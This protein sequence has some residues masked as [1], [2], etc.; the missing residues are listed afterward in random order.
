MKKSQTFNECCFYLRMKSTKK[1]GITLF[2]LIFAFL[3]TMA[4][5]TYAQKTVS[6]KVSD[7]AGEPI[8][9]VTVI[10]KGTTNGSV[11]DMDGIYT[12]GNI[13]EDGI[14]QFSFVGM[15]TQEI[16]VGTQTTIN[17]TLVAD[18]LGL[19]EVVIVGYGTQKKGNLTGSVATIKSEDLVRAP[20]ASTSNAITGRMPGVITKQGSGSPG[21][22]GARISIRGFGEPLVIVDGVVGNFNIIDANEIESISVLKDASAAIYGARAG[23]GVIL[24]TTKRGTS[25]KPKITLNSSYTSQ[26]NTQFLEP[27]S[28]GQ[29]AE[30]QR[31]EWHEKG[32]IGAAPFSEED[33]AKYYAG[34]D[35][36]YPNTNWFDEIMRSS[37]PMLQ[38]NLSLSGGTEDI[39][40]F[41]FLGYLNQQSFLK[42]NDGKYNRYNVRANLDTKITNDLSVQFDVSTIIG[43]RKY[44]WRGANEGGA[45]FQDLWDQQPTYQAFT[46]SEK[47]YPYTGSITS[48]V[49][50]SIREGH[51]Y[52]DDNK[53]NVKGRLGFLY[54][55]PFVKG[56]SAKAFANYSKDYNRQK[57]YER[58]Y[59]TYTYENETDEYIYVSTLNNSRLTHRD[60]EYQEITGQFSLN[61]ERTFNDHTVSALALYEFIDIKSSL[62]TATRGQFLVPDIDYLFGG[63]E[64]GMS[65]NGSAAETGRVSFIGRLNYSYKGKYLFESTI[66]RD[67]SAKF[68]SDSRWGTF[69]SVSLGWR[70]S[71]ESFIADNLPALNNLKLR[72]GAS[73]TGVDDVGN[74]QYLAGYNFRES[75]TFGTSLQKTLWSKGVANPNLS[76]EEITIYNLGL[77]YGLWNNKLYGEIDVFSRDRE[78]IAG[79]PSTSL[80][81]TIGIEPP[82]LNLNSQNTKGFE[83]VIG[84]ANTWNGLKYDISANVSYAR[85]KWIYFDEPE[86][87]DE[88]DIRLNQK[89]GNWIDRTIGY[90]TDGLFTS[91]AEI[92]ALEFDQD[93]NGN[94]TLRPGDIKY[95]DLNN[96]GRLD[97]RDQ[98]VIG[99]GAIP[100]WMFGITTNLSYKNFDLSV[101]FQGAFDYYVYNNLRRGIG[102]TAMYKN[103]WTEENN[104]PN[105]LVPR[106]GSI[107]SGGGYSDFYLT[108]SNYIRL[109]NLSFGYTLPKEWVEKAGI[110]N[111]RLYFAGTNL[112]T[113]DKL[114]DYGVDP[115][116]TNASSGINQNNQHQYIAPLDVRP[117]A[118]NGYYYPQQR[119]LTF[120]LNLTF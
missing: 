62:L 77:D 68:P 58:P 108:N 110:D 95:V 33:I 6:G 56:L 19:E 40:Y 23:N 57:L 9:G 26:S 78:G 43:S 89:T 36:D 50:E 115:E 118:R 8:P 54:S 1:R 88:D 103:R 37:S 75:Y 47:R 5:S 46:P 51:G 83:A 7:D 112:L 92:D 91:Q 113:F 105:A 98:D 76:W 39:K 10:V 44:P 107:A 27:V 45:F 79:Y 32:E 85:T 21:Q 16:V 38:H 109:K 55:V 12:V 66:R 65:N 119:T 117:E 35:P 53:Q 60:V 101:L 114:K 73:K 20:I 120:G 52:Q 106:L 97:W 29:Y 93:N 82:L 18:A 48:I 41:A 80:P 28:S 31:Q 116:V 102:S 70:I 71:E 69:P 14:L 87:T 11:T 67:A 96:D 30:M 13:P 86:Y 84:T 94:T 34:N 25:G 74:F 90:R 61:Y 104:N 15:K 59:S 3:Q 42:S 72:G 49:P 81:N 64:E 63:N 24:V 100:H 4:F 111:L 99:N 22:D 17:I 2:L